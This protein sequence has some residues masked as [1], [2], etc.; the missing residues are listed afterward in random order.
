MAQLITLELPA[1][2]SC[3]FVLL[4]DAVFHITSI[5]HIEAPIQVHFVIIQSYIEQYPQ[6]CNL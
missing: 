6:Y 2:R 5:D 4:K 1:I 3:T